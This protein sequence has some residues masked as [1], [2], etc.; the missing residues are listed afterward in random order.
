ML[1]PGGHLVVTAPNPIRL[2][3]LADPIG[4]VRARLAPAAHGYRRHYWTRRQLRRAVGAS[5]LEVLSVQGHGLGPFTLAGRRLQGDA[6][7][8]ALGE[9]LERLLPASLVNLLGSNLIALAR[10]P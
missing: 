2:A 8:I 7:S 3:Y 9:R 10:K 4:V 1:A 5:G 6:R